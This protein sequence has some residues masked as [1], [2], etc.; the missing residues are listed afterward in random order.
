MSK[1]FLGSGFACGTSNGQ[2][3]LSPKPARRCTQR[4]QSS[5]RV[6]HDQQLSGISIDAL[7][8]LNNGGNCTPF[9]G[10]TGVIMSIKMLALQGNEQIAGIERAG[11]NGIPHGDLLLVKVAFGCRKFSN[12]PQRQF[13][14]LAP[15]AAFK[16]PMCCSASRATLT[17]SKGNVPSRVTWNFSWPFPAMST[18]SP[19]VASSIARAMAFLRSGSTE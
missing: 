1:N 12:T 2:E 19:E 18:T 7:S 17:S 9:K 8:S 5:K 16:Y 3:R 6:F 11:I 10:C 4:L 14:R 13:H 15:S